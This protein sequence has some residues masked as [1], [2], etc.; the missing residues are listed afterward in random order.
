MGRKKTEAVEQSALSVEV[1][2]DKAPDFALAAFQGAC[3]TLVA[4]GWASEATIKRRG[5][6]LSVFFATLDAPA[7]WERAETFLYGSSAFG[8]DLRRASIAVRTGENGWDDYVLLSDP[9]ERP[10]A[11]TA[12]RSAP[13]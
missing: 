8:E 13:H 7:L 12:R 3:E 2:L 10:D 5:E 1:R 11:P 9:G 4:G 6:T